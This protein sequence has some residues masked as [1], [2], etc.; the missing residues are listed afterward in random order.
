MNRIIIRDASLS[1]AMNKFSEELIDCVII[2]LM[3][4]FFEY[5]QLSLIEKCKDMIVF[6]TSLDLMKMITILMKT[7]NFVTQL[8]RMINKIIVDHVAHHAFSFVN[9]IEVKNL[10]TRYNNEFILFKI[11]RYVM[12]H[13]Q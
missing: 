2:S 7:I 3:N 11:R 6:M 9:N 8:V 13:I 5:D 4:L 12:K 10:K 1:S